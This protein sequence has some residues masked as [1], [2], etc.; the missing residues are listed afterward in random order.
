M[1]SV[2]AGAAK[3]T[4]NVPEESFLMEELLGFLKDESFWHAMDAIWNEA[5]V[6]M[7]K[8]LKSMRIVGGE[9]Q[10]VV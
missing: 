5:M 2:D 4:F 10:F 7:I 9:N 1:E 3:K 6:A 8:T